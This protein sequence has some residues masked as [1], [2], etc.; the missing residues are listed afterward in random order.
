MVSNPLAVVTNSLATQR[1]AP[2]KASPDGHWPEIK[3]PGLA[4]SLARNFMT[5]PGSLP[6]PGQLGPWLATPI[7]APSYAIPQGK[8]PALRA[9]TPAYDSG[10]P[11]TP[12]QDPAE[13]QCA[14]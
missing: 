5:L 10:S 3:V 2:S 13:N 7:L 6:M 11:C 9:W 8:T 1:F 4:P 12:S 14:V